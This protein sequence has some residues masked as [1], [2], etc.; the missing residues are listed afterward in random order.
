MH[1][2]TSTGHAASL[3]AN[4]NSEGHWRE[5]DSLRVLDLDTLVAEFDTAYQ[6]FEA[7]LRVDADLR[8][9]VL[10][11]ADSLLAPVQVRL[12][13]VESLSASTSSS[14]S[15]IAASATGGLHVSG[16]LGIETLGAT[17]G[18]AD[19]DPEEAEEAQAARPTLTARVLNSHLVEPAFP[20]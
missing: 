5:V 2:Y 13:A 3:L 15:V 14:L 18:R 1:Y 19:G 4:R 8:R 9:R 7:D 6:Q 11:H 16:G 20:A 17:R 10:P 12:D